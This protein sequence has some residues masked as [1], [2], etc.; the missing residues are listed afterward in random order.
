MKLKNRE[1]FKNLYENIL[2]KDVIIRYRLKNEII[3][4]DLL[5]YLNSNVSKEIIYTKLKN[6][7][8]LSNANTVKEY[9]NYFE[10]A[11]L[12]FAINKF[13]YSI[14]KQILSP[15]KVYS[16][17]TWFSSSVSFEFFQN[18]WKN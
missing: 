4:K 7:L 14:K 10:N 1:V 2:Y 12:L 17:D 13:D 5:Y 9:I 16:I 15:K 8:W 11:Y 18:N 6:I 3:I